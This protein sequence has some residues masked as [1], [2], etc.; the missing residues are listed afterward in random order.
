MDTSEEESHAC[1][2]LCHTGVKALMLSMFFLSLGHVSTQALLLTC[3]KSF[4]ISSTGYSSV[5]IGMRFPS[6]IFLLFNTVICH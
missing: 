6:L 4:L 3:S 1:T 2:F 5:I